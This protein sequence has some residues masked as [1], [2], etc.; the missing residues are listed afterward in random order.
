MKGV[1][2]AILVAVFALSVVALPLA[3]ASSGEHDRGN[4]AAVFTS[5]NDPTGNQIVAYER[6]SGGTLS[7]VADFATGGTGTGA[8]LADSGAL[9]L[10]SNHRWL[11]SVD[12][13]SNQISVF[14]VSTDSNAPL[15]ILADVA[16]SGGV[17]PVSVA[18]SGNFVYVLNDGNSVTP[19]DIA[20]FT[21]SR[22][23]QL[24]PI[25]GSTQSLSTSGAT[26]AAQISFNPSGNF[27]IVTEKATNLLDVYAVNERGVASGATSFASSGST[28][29]GYDFAGNRHLLVSEAAGGSVSLYTLSRSGGLQIVSGSVSDLQKAPCWV[30]VTGNERTAFISNTAS[31]TISSFEI[32]AGGSLSLVQSVAAS[33]DAGPAYMAIAGGSHFL[34]VYDGGA[35]EI[36]AFQIH[37]D[38]TLTWVQTVGGLPAGSEGLVA[39]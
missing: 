10:T 16:A 7:W 11:L 17:L 38:G 39:T 3:G 9:A 22:G 13:G 6:S 2:V 20:G 27:L 25:T 36:Q 15:L 30:V 24:H 21:L 14:R 37:H 34:Y 35:G 5:T 29:Y 1:G 31:N 23:G 26:G 12:A 4:I 8:A 33:T 32:G 28:P 18:I 19:G